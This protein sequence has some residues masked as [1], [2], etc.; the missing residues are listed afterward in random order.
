MQLVLPLRTERLNVRALN[1]DDFHRHFALFSNPDVVRYLYEEPLSRQ[2]AQEHLKRRCVLDLPNEGSWINF[3]VEIADDG[4]LIGELGIAN[5][6]ITHRHYE[7]GY[8]FDPAYSGHGYAT[9]ATAMAVELAISGLGAHRVTARL[10]ARNARSAGVL[11]RLG[12]RREG[13]F[14]E[15]EFVKGEWTDETAY[16]IL[17]DEWRALR[18]PAPTFH[19]RP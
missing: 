15:N 10:D 19:F 2:Q 16:A 6:G 12:M 5:L 3:G 8:V 1:V 14:V 11:E 4:V 18:G 9:E 7:V 17:E 13:R